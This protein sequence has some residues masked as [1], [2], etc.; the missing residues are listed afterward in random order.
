MLAPLLLML[1]QDPLLLQQLGERQRYLP[2]VLAFSCYLTI[3]SAVQ[4]S[5]ASSCAALAATL[6]IRS[7]FCDRCAGVVVKWWCGAAWL[8]RLCCLCQFMTAGTSTLTCGS[9]LVLAPA[10]PSLPLQQHELV[11]APRATCLGKH[12]SQTTPQANGMLN[13]ERNMTA[14]IAMYPLLLRRWSAGAASTATGP[15][16]H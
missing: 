11:C 1:S 6:N 13:M 10:L 7:L 16:P 15:Q 9:S 8:R 4:V 3:T 12:A 2:P 5:R 14:C